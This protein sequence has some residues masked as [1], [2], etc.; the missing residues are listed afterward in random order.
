MINRLIVEQLDRRMGEKSPLIQVMV[1]PR[2]VGKTTALQTVLNSRAGIYHT[3]DYPTPLSPD[4]LETWWREAQATDSKILGIDEIQKVSGWSE[5]LKWLWD[6]PE[7][8]IKVIL[9]GSSALLVEKGLKET[10]A[11]RFELLNIEHWNYHE[12]KTTFSL[13]LDHYIEFGCYPGAVSFLDEIDRW[14]SYI[15]DAIVEPAIGR[16]LLQLHPVD[17]PALLRQ[18]FGLAVANPAQIVSLQK[19][20]GQLQNKGTIPTIQHYLNLLNQSFLVTGLN[21]YS[22]KNFRSKRSSPKLIVHDNALIRAFQRPIHENLS[23]ETYGRYLENAIGARFIEAGWE[24]YYWKERNHEVDFIVIGPDNQKWAIEVKGTATNPKQLKSLL[25]FCKHY[26][27]F[28]PYLI[29]PIEQKIADI[30][31]LSAE[32]AL[33]LSRSK[34]FQ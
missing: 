31:Y 10:L 14:G 33:S 24:T 22:P 11:G 30:N 13:A 1:G 7:N 12:A 2:Q 27:D 5:A 18:V 25:E 9:T 15:R 34:K 17:Q 4:I 6:N 32:K 3:A 20:V 19:M 16:D 26:N 8:R 28:E 23:P 29:S 21:K